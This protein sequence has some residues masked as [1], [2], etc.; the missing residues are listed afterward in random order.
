MTRNEY[1]AA[2]G[3]AP[4]T[5]GQNHEGDTMAPRKPVLV[6]PSGEIVSAPGKILAE[7]P[8]RPRS[9]GPS[10]CA[11]NGDWGTWLLDPRDR[12]LWDPRSGCVVS[13]DDLG[14]SSEMLDSVFQIFGHDHDGKLIAGFLGALRDILSPQANLCSWGEDKKLTKAAIRR[15]VTA[16]ANCPANRPMVRVYDPDC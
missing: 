16:A 3:I 4:V 15:M 10:H 13:L 7:D 8:P 14:R 12:T 2:L 6:T 5:S 11:Y 9:L 1:L